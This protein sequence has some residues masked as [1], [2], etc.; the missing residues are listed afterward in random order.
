MPAQ[1]P[2]ARRTA[3]ADDPL[4]RYREKR[5][6]ARTPEPT[7]DRPPRRARA[8]REAGAPSALRFVVQKHAAGRLH[9][10]L[11]L[12]L[13]GVLKSWALAKGPSLDPADKRLAVEVEDH[14][15]DYA[16]FEGVIGAGYGAGTVMV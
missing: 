5:D 8:A 15:L 13:G 12:E 7:G 1:R 16:G 6:F 11:R 10:D 9:H 14:P 4:A 2:R 3:A